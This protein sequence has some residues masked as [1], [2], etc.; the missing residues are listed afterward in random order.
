MRF[1]KKVE[2]A[3]IKEKKNQSISSFACAQPIRWL[4]A[5]KPDT[6]QSPCLPHESSTVQGWL[7]AAR[8]PT[9]KQST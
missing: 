5:S 8:A 3:G 1:L 2:A 6:H 4:P 9:R 7:C